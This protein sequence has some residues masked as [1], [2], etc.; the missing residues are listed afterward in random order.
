MRCQ[1]PGGGTRGVPGGEPGPPPTHRH[2]RCSATRLRTLWKPGIRPPRS[3]LAGSA[4]AG[5]ALSAPRAAFIG[6]DSMSPPPTTSPPSTGTHSHWLLAFPGRFGR[7]SALSA[8]DWLRYLPGPPPIADTYSFIGSNRVANRGKEWEFRTPRLSCRGRRGARQARSRPAGTRSS[9]A[10]SPG[11]VG[12]R[13]GG[14]CPLVPGAPQRGEAFG[15]GAGSAWQ[16]LQPGAFPG[17]CWLCPPPPQIGYR[18]GGLPTSGRGWGGTRVHRV[19][20]CWEL[21]EAGRDHRAVGCCPPGLGCFWEGLEGG[22]CWLSP[23]PPPPLAQG[24]ACSALW[25]EVFLGRSGGLGWGAEGNQGGLGSVPRGKNPLAPL[26]HLQRG[27]SDGG[28]AG[29]FLPIARAGSGKRHFRAPPPNPARCQAGA[30]PAGW[31]PPLH[32]PS[33]GTSPPRG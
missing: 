9:G 32:H 5:T 33:P 15:G 11:G 28:R 13:L 12:C 31:W 1:A 21:P 4:A 8:F 3:P 27:A 16:C 30:G 20:R 14:V 17:R 24:Q 18:G 19:W 22:H 23:P 25:A 7:W 10:G 6:G 26:I 29:P 2:R